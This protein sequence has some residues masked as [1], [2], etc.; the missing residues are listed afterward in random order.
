[1]TGCLAGICSQWIPDGVPEP[2]KAWERVYELGLYFVKSS[3]TYPPEAAERNYNIKCFWL[4][5]ELNDLSVATLGRSEVLLQFYMYLIHFY[6]A[7]YYL[8]IYSV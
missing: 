3:E 4:W 6:M 1:M 2:I 8:K 7:N 5:L